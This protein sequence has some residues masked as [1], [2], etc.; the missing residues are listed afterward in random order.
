MGELILVV[1]HFVVLSDVRVFVSLLL[2]LSYQ[3]IK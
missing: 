2:H 3:L 1:A